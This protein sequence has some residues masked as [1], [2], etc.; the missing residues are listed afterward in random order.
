[1]IEQICL[2]REWKLFARTSIMSLQALYKLEL[3]TSLK[4]WGSKNPVCVQV[5][6]LTL[7]T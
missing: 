6:T 4:N 2:R 5:K 3:I 7:G 1:M